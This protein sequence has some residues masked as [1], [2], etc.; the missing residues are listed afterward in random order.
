MVI[1]DREDNEFGFTY[2]YRDGELVKLNAVDEVSESWKISDAPWE[3]LR[4]A[5]EWNDANGDYDDS[6]SVDDLRML[7]RIQFVEDQ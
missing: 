5:L 7:V 4:D 6:L 1:G 3:F 2:D